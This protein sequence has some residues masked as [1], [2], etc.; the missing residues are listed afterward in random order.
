MLTEFGFSD[1]GADM[2]FGCDIADYNV[3]S[4]RAFQKAGYEIVAKIEQSAGRKA[5]YVQDVA[6]A[7]E[8][9][10]KQK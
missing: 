7:K 3:R 10:L 1:Q 8:S 9:F 5:N 4:L 2:I 6:L